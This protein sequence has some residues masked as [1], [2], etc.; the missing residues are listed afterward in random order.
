VKHIFGTTT[1]GDRV[2]AGGARGRAEAGDGCV[3]D[4][5]LEPRRG[6]H[7]G[8]GGAKGILR[9]AARGDLVGTGGDY[10]L[11]PACGK[12]GPRLLLAHGDMASCGGAGLLGAAAGAGCM[13]TTTDA[14]GGGGSAKKATD[15]W[16][17]ADV[18]AALGDTYILHKTNWLSPSPATAPS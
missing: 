8:C 9:T 2:G 16:C 6:A 12:T 15:S 7:D 5:V 14:A 13:T 11:P 3:T 4:G 10:V 18:V 1:W 17:A